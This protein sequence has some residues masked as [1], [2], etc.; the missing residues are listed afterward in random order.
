MTVTTPVTGSTADAADDLILSV[1][2]LRTTFAGLHGPV[3]AVQD[4]DLDLRRGTTLAVVGE[5]GSGKSVTVR[6]LLGILDP[7]GR[8][9]AGTALF[10]A[11]AGDAPVDLLQLGP[12][13]TALREVRGKQVGMIFQEPMASLSPM[14]TIGA[15]I[16]EVLRIHL[17]MTKAEARER[18]I[19]LLRRVG[20]A[21]PARCMDSY[22][23]QLSG[24]MCQRAMIALALA[25]DPRLLIADEPTTALDV[26]TQAKV[27]DLLEE[28]T[29]ESNL[30][31]LFITHDLGVVAR[32]ADHVAVM[33]YGALVESGPAAQVF[34]DPQHEYTQQ[35]V[36]AST[37]RPRHARA[38][39]RAE[40]GA[41]APA[42]LLPVVE[43]SDL[44]VTFGGKAR[45]F[46]R[47]AE[48]V[49]AVA[50]VTLEVLPGET[51]GLVGESGSGKT[52]TGRAVVGAQVP[53]GGS[54][55]YRDADGVTHDLVS[56][57]K[58]ARRGFRTDVR[59]VFQDPY[60]SLNP[61]MRLLE[62]LAEP[63]RINHLASGSEMQDRVAAALERVGLEAD[64]MNRYP[65]AFSGGQRQRVNIARALIT[66]PR[67]VV[68]DEAVSALDVSVRAQILE[69]LNGL[70]DD[71]G[72]A[73]LF[74]SHDLSVVESV[75][76][77]VAVMQHGMIVE[78]RPTADLF[79]E[80]QH[81]YTRMLLDSVPVPDPSAYARR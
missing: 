35:L 71:F 19:S 15:H 58:E 51:L 14:Q 32:V 21:D 16:V 78:S 12:K 57:S 66:E 72:L 50:G 73:Y 17:G 10:R 46:S 38:Q 23:F 3:H 24:G 39:P 28:T 7:G 37:V 53:T 54:V 74:I 11:D 70:Q 42:A 33:R 9:E 27:L 43:V 25:C 56:M 13:S 76:D 34:E 5:S 18:G 1:R 44:H 69:L 49:H 30:S 55:V 63:L 62:I 20:I 48:P 68:A 6:S 2:G 61:R 4:V 22:S 77:R 36:R 8:V 67:L 40:S 79:A 52:T 45:A 29:A 64:H 81:E 80:P 47:R 65:H 31:V 60:T 26:T 59:M 75:C 41:S